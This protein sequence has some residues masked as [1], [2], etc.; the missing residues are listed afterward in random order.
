VSNRVYF[1]GML[2]GTT[3]GYAVSDADLIKDRLGSAQPSYAYG[4]DTGSGQQTSPGDD[5]ATYWKDSSSG[6]EYAMNRYYSAGYGRFLTVDPFG[7]SARVGN[8]G[9]MNRYSY[10]LGDPVNL[11]DPT[12]RTYCDSEENDDEAVDIVCYYDDDDTP[13]GL[14]PGDPGVKGGGTSG[15]RWQRVLKK[16]AL[17]QALIEGDLDGIKSD[18]G[19]QHD[20]DALSSASQALGAGG[21]TGGQAIDAV[22][23]VYAIDNTTYQDGLTSTVAASTLN[24]P[25]INAKPNIANGPIENLMTGGTVAVAQL[26]GNNV[27]LNPG[28]LLGLD[29]FS[30][31]GLLM[32]E[33]LHNLG[34]DDNDVKAALGLTNK[35]C[36]DGTTDCIGT[37]LQQDCFPPPGALLLGLP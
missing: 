6:F 3:T 26:G 11:V 19:C 24:D 10:A 7:G 30:A 13:G 34:L 15:A 1:G 5:F 18:S 29:P 9:S 37:K 33:S 36:P 2:L 8:P 35:Q 17:E 22:N 31:A 32:H 16:I 14:G 21:A 25:S 20:I 23:L 4:T 27:Y 28:Y 12:G